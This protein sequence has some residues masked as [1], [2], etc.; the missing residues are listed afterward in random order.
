MPGRE[1]HDALR[2]LAADVGELLTADIEGGAELPFE[3]IE[4][5]TRMSPVLYRYRPLTADFI[6]ERWRRVRDLESY[7]PAAALLAPGAATYLRHRGYHASDPDDAVRDLV[8]RVFEDATSFVL[9]EERLERIRE[10]LDATLAGSPVVATVAAPVHGVRIS[11]ARVELADGLALARRSGIGAAPPSA[12]EGAVGAAET[13][14]MGEDD[15]RAPTDRNPL[16]VFC[17]LERELLPDADMP[18]DEA[19]VQFRRVLT[20][21]RLCGAGGTAL[22]P[23]AWARAGGGAWHP[24]A[25]GVSA[26]SRPESWELVNSEEQELRDLLEVLAHSRHSPTIGWAL[27]RFEMGCDR[28]LETEALSDYLLGLR[29]L[30][31]DPGQEAERTAAVRL[32]ALCAPDDEREVLERQVAR[33]FALERLMTYGHN[34]SSALE[35]DSPH[36]VVRDVERYL[37]ALLRDILCGYLDEDLRSTAD[38]LFQAEPAPPEEG[39]AEISVRDTRAPAAE[40]EDDGEE[41]DTAEFEAVEAGAVTESVDWG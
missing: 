21:L 3:V 14:T 22:G 12:L 6:A 24:V 36:A 5:G 19:R 7:A 23:L 26:R 1:L 41:A 17:V 33:A 35:L 40:E 4:Q 10:E 32:S 8:Q 31:A 15:E 13:S 25:L 18:V 28:A 16:D 27:A 29:A 30:L 9:P 2:R 39:E 20:A 34:P 11:Q 38:E 37:R